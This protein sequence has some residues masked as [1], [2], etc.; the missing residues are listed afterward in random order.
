MKNTKAIAAVFLLLFLIPVAIFTYTNT[1][2]E[3]LS[4]PQVPLLPYF[5]LRSVIRMLIAYAL[6]VVFGLTYGVIAGL[7][8]TARVFMLPVLDILQS[9]PVLGYLPAA[10]LLFSGLLPGELGYEIA[11]VIL[12]FTG[13]AWAVAFSVL[14][15]VRNIPNDLREASNSF[16]YRGWR[17]VHHVVLPAIFPA[18]ITGSILAWGGGWYFLVAAEMLSYGTSVHVLPGIGSFLG[19][20]V[21]TYGNIPAAF[22]GLVVFVAVVFAI[23][24]FIWKP[25]SEFAK[26]YN[27]QTMLSH[28]SEPPDFSEF[29]P[30]RHL[31]YFVDGLEK[32]YGDSLDAFMTGVGKTYGRTLRFLTHVPLRQRRLRQPAL[33]SFSVYTA[34]FLL[35]MLFLA[36]FVATGFSALPLNGLFHAISTHP[37]VYQLPL[38]ALYST[39]RIFI[40]YILALA[41]TLVAGIIVARSKTLSSIFM[42]LFDIGQSTPA[43]ALFPFIV[44]LVI[45]VLGGGP[46]SVEVASVLLLLTGTQWYLFFNIVGAVKSIPGNILEASRAFDLR[47]WQLYSTIII[48]AIIPGVILGS[49]QAWGGAWNALIVSEYITFNGTVYSVP[50]VGAFLTQATTAAVPEPWVITLA[51]A[52]MSI[53]VILM[54]FLVWRPLFTYAERYRFENV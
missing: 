39:S 45:H 9:I 19:T 52:T 16:G 11:S 23:N 31:I 21:F 53:V 35:I 36:Y 25:L 10:I 37:E 2:G 32:K 26:Y 29:G 38:L 42:P 43:L 5:V 17:Y 48:P 27:V 33:F 40:A 12:I 50:G 41:W 8:R 1:W 34:A 13:M 30:V 28:E 47:G 54:N 20:A 18:F 24:S 46:I 7:Y 3:V 22:A 6:V 15:A 44:I 51:V 49:I 14:G 4:D